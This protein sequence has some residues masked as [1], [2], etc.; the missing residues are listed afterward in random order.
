M[1]LWSCGQILVS[2]WLLR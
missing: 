1:G 2:D